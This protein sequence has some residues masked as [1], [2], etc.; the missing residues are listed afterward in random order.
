MDTVTV[1]EAEAEPAALVAVRVT[2]Y[3][4][5]A[6][7][8]FDGLRNREVVPSPKFQDQLAGLPDDVSVKLTV[9]GTGPLAGAMVKLAA[10]ELNTLMT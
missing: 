4:P 6:V 3:R 10:K 2:V 1:C 5:K 7:Y 8:V 9:N